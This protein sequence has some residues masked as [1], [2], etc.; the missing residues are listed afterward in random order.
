MSGSSGA[1]TGAPLRSGMSS[2]KTFCETV[3]A[4]ALAL[5]LGFVVAAG[6]FAALV[7]GVTRSFDPRLPE[8]EA[9]TGKHYLI[10]GGKMAQTVFFAA[11][12]V[13]FVCAM[14]AVLTLIAL[15]KIRSDES[16]RPA[17]IMRA[18]SLVVAVASLASLLLVVNPKLVAATA[19]YWRAAKAGD[20]DGA[21]SHQ[22]IAGDTH[23]Y[24]SAL[25]VTTALMVL[26]SLISCVW[27]LSSAYRGGASASPE[28]RLPEPALLRGARP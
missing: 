21:L 1:T 10:I 18:S 17:M 5:W 27:S 23:P 12:V 25:M 22:T 7:F 20:M 13:Q 24:A 15:F 2:W 28:R 26:A 16:R 6:T 11:D 4:V 3:H 8:F 14:L 19:A 9:Y